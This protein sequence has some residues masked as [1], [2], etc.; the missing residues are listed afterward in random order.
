MSKKVTKVFKKIDPFTA[1]VTDPILG[2]MGL[3]NVSGRNAAAEAAQKQAER[4]AG[5]Q[6]QAVD[7]QA[8]NAVEASRAAALQMQSNADRDRALQAAQEAQ[9]VTTDRAEVAPVDDGSDTAARRKRFQSQSVG[10]TGG[11][12]SIRL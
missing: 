2:N 6:Q 10:G 5:I 7:Q 1:K 8:A 3:P 11:G 4:Q 9:Q 12:T